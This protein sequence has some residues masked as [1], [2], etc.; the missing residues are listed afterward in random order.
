MDD[1]LIQAH[2]DLSTLM[3]YLHLPVQSGSDRIL[4]S[5]NRRH[6]SQSYLDIIEKVR[7]SRDDMALSGDFIVGFPGETEEDFDQTIKLIE[8]VEYAQSYSFKYSMRPGT[9]GALMENQIDEDVKKE[10][11][12]R[13]QSL[14]RDQQKSFNVG[15]VGKTISVLLEKEGKLEDQWVGRSPWLQSVIVPKSLG[16]RG[17]IVD[18]KVLAA[19]KNS[20]VGDYA[21]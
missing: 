2:S 18:V 11:L 13:L 4:K 20:L 6:T 8:Q 12:L 9:P 10:R 17:D 3:P 5:M 21:E 14:L 1:G 15:C 16:E 7:A 19:H